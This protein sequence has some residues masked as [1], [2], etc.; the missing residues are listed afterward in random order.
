GRKKNLKDNDD[1]ESMAIG[2]MESKRKVASKSLSETCR[3]DLKVQFLT[4]VMK[5]Y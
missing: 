2:M 1:D 5:K 3:A 4:A